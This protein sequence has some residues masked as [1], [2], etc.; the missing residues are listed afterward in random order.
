MQKELESFCNFF[1]KSE[2]GKKVA[3]I[4][5]PSLEDKVE[6]FTI[7][8]HRVD[9]ILVAGGFAPLF[10]R[11][12]R[13]WDARNSLDDETSANAKQKDD[14]EQV[15]DENDEDDDEAEGEDEEEE[16]DDEDEEE[17]EEGPVPTMTDSESSIMPVVRLLFSDAKRL[18]VGI[19]LPGDYVLGDEPIIRDEPGYEVE[20]DGEAAEW[21][22]PAV[23][24]QGEDGKPLSGRA[25]WGIPERDMNILDIGPETQER[26]ADI[27]RSAQYV[28]WTGSVGEIQHVEGQGGTSAILDAM[29]GAFENGAKALVVSPFLVDFLRT[30]SGVEDEALTLISSASEELL[31]D[32]MKGSIAGVQALKKKELEGSPENDMVT[33]D[34][35]IES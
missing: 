23:G 11:A 8:L 6:L 4:S 31:V 34:N 16:E 19:H 7:L 26:Y 2:G 33:D 24:A 21:I 32:V 30:V 1:E 18:G 29:S 27:I 20:Y 3:I 35:D 9:E 22:V 12:R 15:E 28:L 17:E 14:D 10:E 13:E 5:G 25:T